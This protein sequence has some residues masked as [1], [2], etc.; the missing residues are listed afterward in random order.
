LFL[1]LLGLSYLCAFWSLGVQVRGL[2]GHDGIL[3]ADRFMDA[4][5]RS[6]AAQDIGVSRWFALPTLFWFGS[7]D[8]ALIGSCVVGALLAGL[9]T[10][11]IFTRIVLPVLWLVYL[12]LS[13]VAREFLSYQWDTLLL[14]AGIVGA[15]LTP[16]AIFHRPQDP[17]P[18]TG[19]RWLVWWLTFRLMLGSGIA[20]LAS[21]DSTWRDLTAMAFH[22]ETQPLPTP[23]AW[24][25]HQ[26]P[27][28]VDRAVTATVLFIELALPW[29]VWS[30]RRVRHV[31]AVSLIGL[32]AAIAATGNY[33]FFNLLTI[34]LS[35]TLLDDQLF[36]RPRAIARPAP[37]PL[38]RG[39]LT[40]AALLIVPLSGM[41][42]ALQ[43]RIRLPG[44][45]VVAPVYR[46]A[47][48]FR[49]VNMYGLF[50]VMT[51]TRPEIVVEGSADGIAWEPY[52]LGYKPGDLSRRPPWVAPHQP[53]LDWQMWFAA[54]GPVE[55]E[56]WFQAF[57]ERLL[58][59]SPAV[60]S[61]LARDPFPGA[62]PRFVRA[63]LYEYR[64][65]DRETRRRTGAWWVREG[66][67]RYY[68]PVS[69]DLV[70]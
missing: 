31:A 2:I 46:A 38:R 15:L 32:Q 33:A 60:R 10:V 64:F 3:P 54:L 49:S 14:E 35:L 37:G 44:T 25:V 29:L 65:A 55:R 70:R 11:G 59:G 36:R 58:E 41:L 1:R 68:G 26:L 20:K 7:S 42:L 52:E 67:R 48:P 18:P 34:A 4:A 50:A 51:T 69:R 53:R 45:S 57:C 16:S 5:H 21:G 40:A 62:P 6:A 8:A 19:A 9:V 22:Y 13:T 43:A 56:P 17:E 23:V 66:P 30:P 12:S 28:V 63:T 24:H 39:I 61:L 27:L 47:A